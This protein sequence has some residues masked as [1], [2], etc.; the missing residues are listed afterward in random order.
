MAGGHTHFSPRDGVAALSQLHRDEP[1]ALQSGDSLAARHQRL[2]MLC[3]TL[4]EI[5]GSDSLPEDSYGLPACT[6]AA[7]GPREGSPAQTSGRRQ[8]TL[9][10]PPGFQSHATSVPAR[11][12][13]ATIAAAVRAASRA[14]DA[15]AANRAA[16]ASAAQAARAAPGS[17][18]QSG[19]YTSRSS[20]SSGGRRSTGYTGQRARRYGGT[21]RNEPPALA[22]PAPSLPQRQRPPGQRQEALLQCPLMHTDTDR[23]QQ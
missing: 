23:I 6:P 21:R 11:A 1:L 10:I 18:P 2:T 9:A 16:T 8:G 17:S 14:A 20:S 4:R 19:G 15:R 3:D 13:A 22:P 7:L 12:T 5:H